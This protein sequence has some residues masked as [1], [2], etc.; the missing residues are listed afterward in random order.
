MS[1]AL[2]CM[3]ANGCSH[4]DLKPSNIM[5]NENNEKLVY[6]LTDFGE[7]RTVEP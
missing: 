1:I 4:G 5:V 7:S 2:T 6:Y 3:H